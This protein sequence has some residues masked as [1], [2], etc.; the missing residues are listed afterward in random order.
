MYNNESCRSVFRVTVPVQILVIFVALILKLSIC[1]TFL[2]T[3]S[4]RKKIPDFLLFS[5]AL[6]DFLNCALYA[7]P[8][9]VI[10]LILITQ[11]FDPSYMNPI[12]HA[13]LIL[14]A[15]SSILLFTII[16][17]DR[18]LSLKVP[19]WHHVNVTKRDIWRGLIIIVLL[20]LC[21]SIIVLIIIYTSSNED[22]NSN[23][24][25]YY[26]VLPGS[27]YNGSRSALFRW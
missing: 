3:W 18:L 21:F 7:I 4:L 16:A 10:L 12:S 15:S 17:L 5:Q 11:K 22:L 20:S 23:R 8:N 13:T 26:M 27:I 2:Q 1:I 19:I 6:F 14:T 24:N 9:V 25:N